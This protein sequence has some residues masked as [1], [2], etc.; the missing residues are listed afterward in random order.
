MVVVFGE[1]CMFG[2]LTGSIDA[3]L[4]GTVVSEQVLTDRIQLN[5]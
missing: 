4:W 2:S 5:F 3:S 1:K